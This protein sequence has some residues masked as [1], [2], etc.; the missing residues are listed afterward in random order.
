MTNAYVSLD[1]LK[2]SSVLN[3]TGTADD[4]RLR[5][6]A[7]NAGRIVDRYCNRHFYVVVATRR[8]DGLGT[9]SLLVP[10]LVSVDGGG[11]KT[12]DDKDRVFETTWAASDYLLLPT[13]ADPTAGGNSQSRPYVEVAVDVDAGTKSAFPSGM[14]T[15]QIAGQWGWWRHLRRATETAN[16]V[17]DATT[18]SVTVSSRA[19]VEAGHTLLIDSEQIYVQSYAASTLTV[20]RGVNGTTAASH[21]GGAAVDIYEYPGP[22]VEATI[23]QAAH[24]WRR[25]DSAFGSFGGLPGTGQTR[26]SA[27]LDPDVALLLGQ[28]RKFAVGV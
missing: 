3:V 25:K 12:D 15:V 28:Y 4:S 10:D 27:G 5:A 9:P 17:A 11:L 20:V 19:D 26:I 21:S 2:S 16:A 6:L 13:N 24:L 8:F 7:E 23:I 22:I 1:T 14:Q 18:T